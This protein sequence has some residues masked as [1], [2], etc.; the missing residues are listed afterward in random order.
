M[1]ILEYIRK[2]TSTDWCSTGGVPFDFHFGKFNRTFQLTD[3]CSTEVTVPPDGEKVLSRITLFQVNR[4]E[5]QK[6]N[7]MEP[8]GAVQ[9][10]FW[11]STRAS[12]EAF[13]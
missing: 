10:S 1:R 2:I 11:C 5:H 4:V 9:Y 3:W 13:D 6:L 7:Q 12:A 8:Y